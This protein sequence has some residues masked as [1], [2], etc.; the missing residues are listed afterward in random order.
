[1][2]APVL[3]LVF[4]CLVAVMLSQAVRSQT[5]GSLRV[6][7]IQP[8]DKA[9]PGQILELNV[10]GLDSGPT[11][12]LPREDFRVEV[13]QDGITQEARLR[14]VLPTITRARNPDGTPGEVKPIHN[15]SFVVPRGLHA[16][17]AEVTLY[18]K[19]TKANSIPLTIVDRPLK[20]VIGGPAVITM[21]PA[22]LP[23]P[24]T[25]TRVGEMGWRFERDSKV[26]LFVKPLPDP[27][28]PTASVVIRFKQGNEFYDARAEVKHQPRRTERTG[29]RG[30]AFLPPRD[31]L[32][33]QI[34]AALAMGPADMEIKLRANGSES[35]PATVKVQITD[36]TR[37]AEAPVVNAPRLLNVTPRRVGAGQAL[38]LSVD[39]LRTLNPDPAQT[40]ALIERDNAR[41]IV[42]PERNTALHMPNPRP[43]APVLIVVR[44][45][46]E[47]IGPAQIRLM[48]ALKGEQGGTSTPISIEIVDETLPPEIISAAESTEA[49]LAR[50]REMYELER[51]ADRRFSA[52]DPNSRYL[53]IRGRGIDPN[54]RFVRV[55]LEQGGHRAVLTPSEI[56]SLSTDLII[57]RLPAGFAA[58]QITI[59][60]ANVG[61]KNL[62]LP[63]TI[64]FELRRA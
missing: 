40:V 24:S 54:R 26:Q 41:Y 59:S 12:L 49:D 42:R 13:T 16:G 17:N 52:Y 36:T 63:A 18:H 14:L 6:T 48:N 56:S 45:T 1:M 25:G 5:P 43:D 53:T 58:G 33:V 37:S 39:Y 3:T 15:I 31:F 64:N 28:E 23:P 22:S 38:I 47:I 60:V 50:L 34:P 44:T 29:G 20:P 55:V 51:A 10:E 9:V 61:A 11:T 35:D 2:R 8:F 27:D 57:A 4:L 19:G 32:E 7:R 30:V 62:S 46:Q 21:S